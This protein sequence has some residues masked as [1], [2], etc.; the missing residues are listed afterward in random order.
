MRC[1]PPRRA[2]SLNPGAS[3][4]GAI[5]ASARTPRLLRGLTSTAQSASK[6]KPDVEKSD[7]ENEDNVESNC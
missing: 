7:D 5:C 3:D 1:L 6:L 4:C 2:I